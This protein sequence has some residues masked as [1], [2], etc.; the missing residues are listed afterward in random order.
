MYASMDIGSNSC[1][2]LLARGQ[3]GSKLQVLESHLRVPRIGEGMNQAQ[4][5]IKPEA[6]L[7]TIAALEDFAAIIGK[8]PVRHILLVATQAVRTAANSAELVQAVKS[9]TGWD[10]QI[11]SGEREAWLSYL[12]ATRDLGEENRPLVIDIGGG[13]TEFI[14]KIAE[15]QAK[16]RSIPLGALKLYENPCDDNQLAD[17]LAAMLEGFTR[18]NGTENLPLLGVGG[19]CTTAAAVCLGLRPY[20]PE[21]VQGYKMTADLIRDVH[22]RLKAMPAARRLNVAGIYPGREDIIVPGLRILLAI[23]RYFNSGSITVSDHDLLLGLIYEAAKM[24]V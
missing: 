21:R 3:A 23:L 17:F 8:Y 16:V 15:G 13:S 6:M 14:R 9:R 7:R 18:K 20:D 2:L 19:T 10:L 22:D 1:R 24:R 12:G 5:F 11:I 4:P